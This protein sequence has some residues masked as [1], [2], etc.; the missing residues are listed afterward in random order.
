MKTKS[1]IFRRLCLLVLLAVM[2]MCIKA[3]MVE[4]PFLCIEKTNGEV[5]KVPNT[6]PPVIIQGTWQDALKNP[7]KISY[8]Q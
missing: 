2:P 8:Q 6:A 7:T 4:K 5:V 1:P 3:Q